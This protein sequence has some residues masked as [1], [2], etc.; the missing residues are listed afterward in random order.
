MATIGE[1]GEMVT[2]D[3]LALAQIILGVI[4]FVLISM[5]LKY[6]FDHSYLTQMQWLIKQW[7]TLFPAVMLVLGIVVLE[8]M[9]GE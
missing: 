1:S 8:V 9:M 3:W 2:K 5:A 4:A 6:W 7:V